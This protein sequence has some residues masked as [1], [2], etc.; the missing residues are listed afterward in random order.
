MF[1]CFFPDWRKTD[2]HKAWERKLIDALVSL[3]ERR[4]EIDNCPTGLKL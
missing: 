2:Q 1:C 3:L 4:T